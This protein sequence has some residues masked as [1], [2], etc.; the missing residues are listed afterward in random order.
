MPI[1]YVKTIEVELYTQSPAHLSIKFNGKEENFSIFTSML[2]EQG[3]ELE[4]DIQQVSNI[5]INVI[6]ND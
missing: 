3:N 2:I 5:S 6:S 4:L 1:N